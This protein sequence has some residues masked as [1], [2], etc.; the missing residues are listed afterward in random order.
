MK[1]FIDIFDCIY[2]VHPDK[3]EDYLNFNIEG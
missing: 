3:G 1:N 2:T